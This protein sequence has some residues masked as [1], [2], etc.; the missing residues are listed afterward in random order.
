MFW[1]FDCFS[2][3]VGRSLGGG[4]SLLL[5][6]VKNI[7]Y[8]YQCLIIFQA[9]GYVTY[10]FVLAKTVDIPML[11]YP[12]WNVGRCVCWHLVW[13]YSHTVS[14]LLVI[15][16]HIHPVLSMQLESPESILLLFQ[17]APYIYYLMISLFSFHISVGSADILINYTASVASCMQC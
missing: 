12:V 13:T 2:R 1:C 7:I 17:Y 11:V 9:W 6:N 4:D 16:P 15:L 10:F 14:I 3:I 8:L 5:H